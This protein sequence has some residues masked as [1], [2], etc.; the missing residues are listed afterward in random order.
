MRRK[1]TARRIT[2][3]KKRM[4]TLVKAVGSIKAPSP[5]DEIYDMMED[6][7]EHS[8]EDGWTS[9]G[10]ARLLADYKQV[11]NFDVDLDIWM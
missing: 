6:L 10:M 4:Q 1:R 11:R 2:K 5:L 7:E 8:D 9:W 3:R